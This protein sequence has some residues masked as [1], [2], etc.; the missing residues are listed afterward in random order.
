M[1]AYLVSALS[2]FFATSVSAQYTG[3]SAYAAGNKRF[4]CGRFL[5]I[6][7]HAKQPAMA[8]LYS[9]FGRSTKCV[10]RFMAKF[11]A[12]PHLVEYHLSNETCRRGGRTCYEQEI[13]AS[14]SPRGYSHQLEKMP[15]SLRVLLEKRVERITHIAEQGNRNTRFVLSL[16]LEDQYT[17][18]AA[19]A[20]F[21]VVKKSWPYEIARNP[22][23]SF[24]VDRNADII[25]LHSKDSVFSVDKSCIWN[26]DGLSGGLGEAGQL[27][28]KYKSCLARIAWTKEAQGIG[29]VFVPPLKRKFVITKRQVL[30]YGRLLQRSSTDN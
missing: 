13:L 23:A 19:A 14:L 3:F 26:Q 11:E 22:A 27:F 10:R 24:F 28:R 18:K 30:G 9:T 2:L 17:T 1:K 25:E 15:S 12:R 21:D 7:K 16:G 4:P 5:E 20:L 8:V 6:S 29:E